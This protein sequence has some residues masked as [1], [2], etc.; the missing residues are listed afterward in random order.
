MPFPDLL[1]T[2]HLTMTDP[3]KLRPVPPPEG[4]VSV[5]QLAEV[6]VPF[7]LF[8]YREVGDALR[9][10]D[11]LLMPAE[12]LAAELAQ[13]EVS[14]LSVGGVPAGYIELAALPDGATEV[15]YFGLRAA[16]HG[17]GLGKYLL[18]YGLGRA[19]ARQPAYVYVHTCNL[20]GAYALR[21]YES[22][23]FEVARV[24]QVPMPERY[25]A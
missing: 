10:R 17:R 7:Y 11:R 9:W 3:A 8:L 14:V 22:C 25:K 21:T 24:E 16:Y 1:I 6:D 12:A 18:G 5:R 19:W 2:T 23:G 20:D 13:A 4:D 15:A